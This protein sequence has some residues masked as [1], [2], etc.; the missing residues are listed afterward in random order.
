MLREGWD[1]RNVTTIVPLRPYSSKANILPEQTLGRGLRRMTAPG[2]VDEI[3]TVVE[4][5]AFASLYQ[6]EL[7]QEGLEIE[8]V[9]IDKVPRT[10][11][12]IY[13][14]PAKPNFE[15]LDVELPQ[16]VQEYH[17]VAELKGLGIE[18]V[19]NRFAK[20]DLKPLRMGEKATSEIDYEGRTLL[21]DEVVQQMKIYIPLLKSGFGAVSYYR[22]QLERM[23]SIRG[24]HAVLAPLLQSFFEEILFEEKRNLNDP[25]LV[26]RLGDGDVA[27]HI[28]A[29]FV[30]LIRER[31]I[32][33]EHRVAAAPPVRLS[34]WKPFQATHSETRPTVSSPGIFLT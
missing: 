16:L 21:T 18:N 20:M 23:C 28:R 32:R 31:T 3:L 12:T 6:Q 1:V 25:Q 9:E 24:T 33:R 7:S 8:V 11:V 17:V 22:E 19:R 29:V 2:E 26:N 30:P 5:K 34:S 27:E 10:T 14:D 4:H 13:P 15:K